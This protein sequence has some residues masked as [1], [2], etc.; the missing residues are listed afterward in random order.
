[1]NELKHNFESECERF[2][3]QVIKKHES[4]KF[5]FKLS[6]FQKSSSDA[7]KPSAVNTNA[8]NSQ[9]SQQQQREYLKKVQFLK[10]C[11]LNKIYTLFKNKQYDEANTYVK[12]STQEIVFNAVKLTDDYEPHDGS[13]N[14]RP[15]TSSV[16]PSV[17]ASARQPPNP[18]DQTVSDMVND[19]DDDLDVDDLD[20]DNDDDDDNDVMLDEYG[21]GGVSTVAVVSSSMPATS[22]LVEDVRLKN[23]LI[24]L[25]SEKSPPSGVSSNQTSSFY[26]DLVATSTRWSNAVRVWFWRHV[27]EEDFLLAVIVP[28]TIVVSLFVLTIV[29]ACVLHMFNKGSWFFIFS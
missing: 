17:V 2:F 25:K 29:V 28:I 8:N 22:D 9:S 18:L 20:D 1:M 13:S 21:G 10:L 16:M 11:D 4:L 19:D 7:F 12:N 23:R 26:D 24:K 14:S 6:L 5:R 15:K 27:P 3:K